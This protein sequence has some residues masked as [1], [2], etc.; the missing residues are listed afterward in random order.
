MLLHKFHNSEFKVLKDSELDKSTSLLI[1]KLHEKRPDKEFTLAKLKFVKFGEAY[2][3]LVNGE[4]SGHTISI[5]LLKDMMF[6]DS[7]FGT[8]SSAIEDIVNLILENL[9]LNPL[10]WEEK[11]S[12]I[13]VRLLNN[14]KMRL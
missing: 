9:N 10:T 2:A 6:L 12:A 1:E 11:Q 7:V 14:Q 3:L 13:N 5:E 8:L 4:D